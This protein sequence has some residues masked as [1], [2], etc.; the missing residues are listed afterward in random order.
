MS[1]SEI[2]RGRVC[3][4]RGR[5][6][7]EPAEDSGQERQ[8]PP[9]AVERLPSR[10]GCEPTA[11]PAATRATASPPFSQALPTTKKEMK[12]LGTHMTSA[13]S[14]S[15]QRDRGVGA[16]H[17]QRH[18][19][20]R[21]PGGDDAHHERHARPRAR[22]AWPRRRVGSGGSEQS[23]SARSVARD[24]ARLPQYV[25]RDAVSAGVAPQ[26]HRLDA[27]GPA[28]DIAS[29]PRPARARRAG[30]RRGLG[31]PEA[32][33]RGRHPGGK[34]VYKLY[35]AKSQIAGAPSRGGLAPRGSSVRTVRRGV[36]GRG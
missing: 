22:P 30:P 14:R 25:H 12:K 21:V 9:V 7:R 24:R 1:H 8:D 31:G 10:R 33:A 2:R 13:V 6:R 23:W 18:A 20:D 5:S 35:V 17:Q 16:G 36:K 32:A 3:R 28:P 11:A 15:A 27:H 26:G 34:V 19:G 4:P 29:R